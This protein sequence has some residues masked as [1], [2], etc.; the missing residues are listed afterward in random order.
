MDCT[1]WTAPSDPSLSTVLVLLM[2]L[3]SKT[4]LSSVVLRILCPGAPVKHHDVTKT[5]YLVKV[6]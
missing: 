3:P 1:C 5:S 2:T 4:P 6:T